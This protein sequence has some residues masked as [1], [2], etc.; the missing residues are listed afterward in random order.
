MLPVGV[1]RD[2]PVP[3]LSDVAVLM[4][5]H[6]VQLHGRE[7]ADYVRRLRRELPSTCEIWTAVSVGRERVTGRGGDRLVFDNG[8]GGSG[9]SFDWSAVKGHPDLGNAILAGGIGVANARP[10][11]RLGAFAIDVGS[12][13]DLRP[14]LKSPEKIGSLFGSLRP[15]A[16]RRLG[17]CA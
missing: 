11:Q 2:A 15:A 7:D 8:D 10:A 6:A 1:F 5:L 9:R 3:T 13:V 17:A 16:R 14:G 12:S 4:N